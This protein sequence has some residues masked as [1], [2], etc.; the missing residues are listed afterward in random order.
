MR[1]A[2][3]VLGSA[4][5]VSAACA[6]LGADTTWFASTSTAQGGH[7]QRR[8]CTVGRAWPGWADHNPPYD[9]STM[10]KLVAYM[11]LSRLI[12]SDDFAEARFSVGKAALYATPNDVADFACCIARLSDSPGERDEM[13][14]AGC[15]RFE[16][17]LSWQRPEDQSL[18]AYERAID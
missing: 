9:V 7:G 5:C 16:Q 3:S 10:N 11:A 1:I 14:K 13:G 17:E 8:A 2:I 12:V 6:W 15:R 18:A 4:G